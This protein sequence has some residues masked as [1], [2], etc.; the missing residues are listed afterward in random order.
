MVTGPKPIA[1]VFW[2]LIVHI[3]ASSEE[4]LDTTEESTTQEIPRCYSDDWSHQFSFDNKDNEFQYSRT[5]EVGDIQSSLKLTLVSV[6]DGSKIDESGSWDPPCD[7]TIIGR[8]ITG[9]CSISPFGGVRA[10]QNTLT[11]DNSLQWL[12][13][14]FLKDDTAN[15]GSNEIDVERGSIKFGLN[16]TNLEYDATLIV[17]MT[18]EAMAEY[19]YYGDMPEARQIKLRERLKRWLLEVGTLEFGEYKFNNELTAE[20]IGYDDINVIAN[21]TRRREFEEDGDK[22][23]WSVSCSICYEFEYCEGGN[24]IYD[25]FVYYE[26]TH[27][28]SFCNV[29]FYM[30][31][32]VYILLSILNTQEMTQIVDLRRYPSNMAF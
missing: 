13:V 24:I 21:I 9:D 18:A 29:S 27:G 26:G 20:C 14:V 4:E 28:F 31:G 5:C 3:N 10:L 1:L 6:D 12:N 30:F 19:G 16:T 23:I 17:C 15:I 7:H 2:F 32:F 22:G 11:T 8:N 25:P